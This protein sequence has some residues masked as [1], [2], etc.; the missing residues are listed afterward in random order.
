GPWNCI[1]RSRRN[2][3]RFSVFR[4]TCRLGTCIAALVVDSSIRRTLWGAFAALALLALVGLVLTLAVMQM[5]KRQEYR[6]VHGSEPLID[7]VRT[8]DEDITT[9][10]AAARGYHLTRNTQFQQQHADAARAFQK[11]AIAAAP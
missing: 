7:D 6:I 10:L 8:M 5:G 11:T 4:W 1:A 2:W 3:F 9:M